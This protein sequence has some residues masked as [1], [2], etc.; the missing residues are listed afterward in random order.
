MEGEQLEA[1]RMGGFSRPVGL[2]P[3]SVLPTSDVRYVGERELGGRGRGSRITPTAGP[4]QVGSD[5]DT[6]LLFVLEQPEVSQMG[7]SWTPV[8]RVYED[9]RLDG[10]IRFPT[11]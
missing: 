2:L 4:R 8:Q 3:C 5:E 1:M 6:G 10:K 7:G 11:R 9:Y